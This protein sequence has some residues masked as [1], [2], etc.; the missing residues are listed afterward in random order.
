[1]FSV[2]AIR[3]TQQ[4]E[5]SHQV[6]ESPGLSAISEFPGLQVYSRPETS[7]VSKIVRKPF[8]RVSKQKPAGQEGR[9]APSTV[10]TGVLHG[11]NHILVPRVCPW[12]AEGRTNK[13]V[14]TEP[15][16]HAEQWKERK[17]ENWGRVF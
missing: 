11:R 7:A 10:E 14:C 5:S 8:F 4:G 17:A 3:V 9:L 13:P 2:A 1:M 15:E 12:S 6:V 16:A